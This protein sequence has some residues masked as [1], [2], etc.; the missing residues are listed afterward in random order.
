[1]KVVLLNIIVVAK[2][3]WIVYNGIAALMIQVDDKL[4]LDNRVGIT[5]QFIRNLWRDAYV[6]SQY[7]NRSE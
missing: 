5:F 7:I 3:I 2:L 1:V 6:E 4:K